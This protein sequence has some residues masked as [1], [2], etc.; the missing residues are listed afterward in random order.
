MRRGD[1]VCTPPGEQ[2]TDDTGRHTGDG[3]ARADAGET[4]REDGGEGEGGGGGER[5]G[6][7][8]AE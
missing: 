7:G 1:A 3:G 4:G 2:W 6:E 5:G 8:G